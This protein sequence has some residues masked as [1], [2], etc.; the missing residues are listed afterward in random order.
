ME[1]AFNDW[2]DLFYSE[3]RNFWFETEE[4]ARKAATLEYQLDLFLELSSFLDT[5]D[6]VFT[7]D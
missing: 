3:K 6:L 7:Y 1:I 2:T 4:F 5:T